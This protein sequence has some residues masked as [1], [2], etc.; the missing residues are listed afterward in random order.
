METY[1]IITLVTG[2]IITILGILGVGKNQRK[3]QWLIQFI[4]DIG[5]RI[6]LMVIGIVIIVTSFIF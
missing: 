6:F 2:I 3:N 5:Y 1:S 4:G